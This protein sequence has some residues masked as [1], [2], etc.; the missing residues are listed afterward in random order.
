MPSNFMQNENP[1]R[2]SLDFRCARTFPAVWA[3]E[4][5]YVWS[6]VKETEA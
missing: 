5:V 3:P 2:R 1:R 4:E 6:P